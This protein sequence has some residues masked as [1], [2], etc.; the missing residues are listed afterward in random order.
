MKQLLYILVI[1]LAIQGC[2]LFEFDNAKISINTQIKNP[3]GYNI[4][5]GEILVDI[6]SGN[7]P[8]TIR[9]HKK[10][11]YTIS[12]EK[13]LKNIT[14]G[15]YF[16]SINDSEGKEFLD[17]F[18]LVT[19]DTI[20]PKPYLPAYPG[21]YWEYSDG[22]R[23]DCEPAYKKVIIYNDLAYPPPW[24]Y[25]ETKPHDSIYVPIYN[26]ASIFEYSYINYNNFYDPLIPFLFETKD[27][28]KSISRDTR[29]G[30][31]CIKTLTV[32]TTIIINGVTFHDVIVTINSYL[33]G[34]SYCSDFYEYFPA[35][36]K[37]YY[38]KNIGMIKEEYKE[39][40]GYEY[41]V[42][43]EIENWHINS[44]D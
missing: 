25:Y 16:L 17:S 9:W 38:A 19:N 43:R 42:V 37:K 10:S 36:T 32:D 40:L 7:E 18:C 30:V 27:Q 4:A 15:W 8:Y 20:F 2:S 14:S 31:N 3:S 12:T 22:S 6:I 44:P 24:Q 33:V 28:V 26:G 11:N 23:I 1:T 13:D 34:T 29:H 5:D 35:I 21:S 41:V 39:N